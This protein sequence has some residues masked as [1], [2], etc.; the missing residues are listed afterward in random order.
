MGERFVRWPAQVGRNQQRAKSGLV[1][2]D[3]DV[4][5]VSSGFGHYRSGAEH[6]PFTAKTQHEV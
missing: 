3:R 6:Q 2:I 4:S 1:R 5:R